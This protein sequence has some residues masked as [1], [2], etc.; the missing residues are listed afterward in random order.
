MKAFLVL[1]G[2]ACGCASYTESKIAL[3]DQVRR[4][5][6]ITRQAT[7]VRQQVVER[8]NDLQLQRLDD[9]FDTDVKARARLETDWVIEHRKAYVVARDAVVHQKFK[10]RE[11]QETIDANLTL[12]DRALQQLQLMH[13]VE[14]KFSTLEVIR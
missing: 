5:V 10:L 3:T 2:L 1:I 9:A 6:E 8:L 11:E 12:M 4:G 14:S 7:A 13:Q